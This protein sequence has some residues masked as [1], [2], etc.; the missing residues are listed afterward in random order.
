METYPRT[1]SDTVQQEREENKIA[2]IDAEKSAGLVQK[3]VHAMMMSR[4]ELMTVP[5]NA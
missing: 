2:K 3:V 1:S 5:C 4:A